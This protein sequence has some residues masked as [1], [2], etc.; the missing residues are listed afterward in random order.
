MSLPMMCVAG[1]YGHFSAVGV[2]IAGGGD[3]VG[4]RV[5]PD[6]HHMLF[7]ARHRHAPVEGRARDRQVLQPGFD[8]AHDLVAA[9]RRP[10]EVGIVLVEG[11]QPVLIGREPEEIALL[12]DPFD[13]RAERLAAHAVVA[14]GRF[15]LV[16]IGFLPHRIPA[17]VAV[18][19]D[20]AIRRHALPD[21]LA[22]LVV[23]LLGGADEVV[24]GAAERLDHRAEDR[25][26]AVG[27]RLRRYRLP[28]RPSAAS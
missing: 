4:Q 18:E 11:E 6:I 24:V 12:L 8:E 16:E 21:R 22:G 26:V 5:D 20:V 2:R 23:P 28:G 10:D 27:Q 3:V 7:V 1:Q 14:D 17:A 13:R 15:L 9:L 25:R 19:V